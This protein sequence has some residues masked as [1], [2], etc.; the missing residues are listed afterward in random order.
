MNCRCAMN[1]HYP[2]SVWVASDL[3]LVRGEMAWAWGARW[4]ASDL[5]W[6]G[7]YWE[8]SPVVYGYTAGM[9]PGGLPETWAGKGII[10]R[11][12]GVTIEDSPVVYI[13]WRNG[14][15]YQCK[16][17]LGGLESYHGA[18]AG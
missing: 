7:D 13:D 5:G 8:D 3:G 2:L 16:I 4:V 15:G 10:G 6:Y 18:G 11:I 17:L 1:G 12:G 14:V 9:G